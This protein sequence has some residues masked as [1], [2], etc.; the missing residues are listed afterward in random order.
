MS[1]SS[2]SDEETQE[3]AE[4]L[5]DLLANQSLAAAPSTQVGEAQTA[6]L[7]QLMGHNNVLRETSVRALLDAMGGDGVGNEDREKRHV[8][9]DTQV[10]GWYARR[11]L[12]N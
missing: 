3:A 5:S 7:R 8:F 6:A 1:S 4:I 11:N 12:Y 2:A 9:W 10:R